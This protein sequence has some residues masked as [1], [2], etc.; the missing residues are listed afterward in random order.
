[1]EEPTPDRDA[2]VYRWGGYALSV[3]AFAAFGTMLVGL[4]WWFVAG[5]PGG[6]AGSAKSLPLSALLPRLMAL[7]PS[8]F[9]NLG[10]LLLLITPTATLLCQIGAHSIARTWRYAGIAILVGAILLLGLTISILKS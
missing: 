5:T 4:I 8:A 7:D 2:T 9:L 6:D 1:M 3:G 10:V